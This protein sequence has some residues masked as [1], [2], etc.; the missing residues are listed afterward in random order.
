[1][2]KYKATEDTGNKEELGE[3]KDRRS[4]VRRQNVNSFSTG[5]AENASIKMSSLWKVSQ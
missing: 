5:T 2:C 3:K 1:M 4:I